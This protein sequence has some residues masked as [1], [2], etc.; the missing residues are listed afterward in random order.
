[1]GTAAGWCEAHQAWQARV[2]TSCI[3]MVAG[4]CKGTDVVHLH[5]PLVL[6]HHTCSQDEYKKGISAWNFDVAALKAQVWEVSQ[7][8][9][10][11]SQGQYQGG[12]GMTAAAALLFHCCVLPRNLG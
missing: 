7:H 1:M 6:P 2:F 11:C 8:H 5:G 4:R 3:M 12:V 9:T 10:C